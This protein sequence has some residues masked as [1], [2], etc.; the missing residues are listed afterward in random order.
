MSKIVSERVLF[1]ARVFRNYSLT[2]TKR[3]C[4]ELGW[5]EGTRVDII[6]TEGR[7]ELREVK[8]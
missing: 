2:L 6:Q 3:V 5:P 4:E 1:R 8:P 7:I